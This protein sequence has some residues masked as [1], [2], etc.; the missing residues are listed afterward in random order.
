LAAHIDIIGRGELVL[1]HYP[2]SQYTR[3]PHCKQYFTHVCVVVVF[4]V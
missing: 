3:H 4:S 2:C 1:G